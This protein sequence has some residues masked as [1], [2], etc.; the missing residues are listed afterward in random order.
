[1]QYIN[2]C[3][4]C[5][6]LTLFFVSKSFASESL[7]TKEIQVVSQLQKTIESLQSTQDTSVWPGYNLTETP[8]ILSF[9][10]NHY[11]AFNLQSNNPEWKTLPL[12]NKLIHY[13]TEDHW[14]LN[15][16]KMQ[17]KFP[18]E[19]QEAFVFSID[20]N[21]PLPPFLSIIVLIHERFHQFQFEHFPMEKEGLGGYQD[22]ANIENLSL[23]Q[24]E[25][26]ILMDFLKTNNKKDK[27]EHLKNFVA[28]N[29][30][31]EAIISPTSVLWERNQQTMEG[32]A[33]YVSTKAFD[34]AAVVPRFNAQKHVTIILEGIKAE[35]NLLDRAVKRR[36]YGVGAALGYGLDFLQVDWK[37]RV[38][39]EGI[40]LDE[41]MQQQIALS[42]DELEERVAIV[43]ASYHFDYLLEKTDESIKSF[44]KELSAQTTAY[45]ELQGVSVVM[46]SP[47]GL[48][49][50]GG[51]H[52]AHMYHLPDGGTL[53]IANSS[54]N[55]SNDNRWKL[56][57][58]ETPFLWQ[59]MDGGREFKVDKNTKITI[60][61]KDYLVNE[62]L[63][64]E[65]QHFTSLSATGD[66][67]EIVSIDHPGILKVSENKIIISY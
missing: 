32:L 46:H 33:D 50:S 62:L 55:I 29:T 40:G 63:N 4:N 60:N 36:H 57:L 37:G 11:Y 51:G 3:F 44:Q 56:V 7:P 16:V 52:D 15:E 28:I 9:G 24:V 61:S 1:M 35:K 42:N 19:G 53:S 30:M 2:K 23:M 59:K 64:M 67:G 10:N 41:L 47:E 25:E 65:E 66:F 58:D 43:K 6:L 49:I 22:H 14:G 54:M 17:S 45:N 5:F 26:L 38:Q 39:S 18:I 48:G 12:G 21:R 34:V 31:R 20:L 13:S 8:I 27:L